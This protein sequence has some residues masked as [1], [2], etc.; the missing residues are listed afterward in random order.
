MYI[1]IGANN[2][3]EKLWT[4]KTA[5]SG[6][7]INPLNAELNPICHLLA[8][9]GGATIV[10]VNRLRVKA[11]YGLYIYVYVGILLPCAY[12]KTTVSI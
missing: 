12:Q 7:L 11:V 10:V 6:K 8:L 5:T 9:L 2:N 1:N 4:K 3:S